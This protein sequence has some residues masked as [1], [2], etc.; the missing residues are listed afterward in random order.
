MNR[1][2]SIAVAS[3]IG[4]GWSG[5]IHCHGQRVAC[6]YNLQFLIAC[7]HWLPARET[8]ILSLGIVGAANSQ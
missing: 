7:S 8:P 3:S 5:S 6:S 4:S 1:R 2:L